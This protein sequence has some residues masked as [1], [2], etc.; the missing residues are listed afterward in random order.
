ML[1]ASPTPPSSGDWLANHSTLIVGV[2]GIVV[3]GILG[4][5][6]TIG[7][8]RKSARRQFKRDLIVARR[9]D[10][11]RLLDEAALLLGAGATNLRL[12]KEGSD[13]KPAPPTAHEWARS[14]FPLGQRLRLRLPDEH[15]VVRAYD[16]VRQRLTDAQK[17]ISN[18]TS[19]SEALDRYEQAR[20]SFLDAARDAVQAPVNEDQEI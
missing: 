18:E 5:A 16:D 1:A 15:A 2:V 19:F 12:L 11:A 6:V 3:S 13:R 8:S 14:I 9:D 17:A 20:A 10:L 7:L 4:P